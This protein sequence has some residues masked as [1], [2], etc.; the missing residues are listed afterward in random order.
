MKCTDCKFCISEDYGYSNYTV[1]GTDVDCLLGLNVGLP[2]DRFYGE[3][4]ELD[5]AKSCPRFSKG[6]GPSMCVEDSI[7]DM[8]ANESDPEVL[9]AIEIWRKK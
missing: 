2:K 5:V 8:V 1:E 7:D 9:V 3:T 6:E 4:P